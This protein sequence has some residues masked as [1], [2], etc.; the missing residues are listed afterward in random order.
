MGNLKVLMLASILSLVA[1]DAL[2]GGVSAGKVSGTVTV[3]GTRVKTE[4]AKS[5]KDVLQKLLSSSIP[6]T[7]T[8]PVPR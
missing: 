4:G 3:S 6:I 2:A 1:H 5:D 7:F 8:V